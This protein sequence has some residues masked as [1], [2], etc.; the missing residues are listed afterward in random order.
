[1]ADGRSIW[2]SDD[3][4][5]LISKSESWSLNLEVYE[6]N[7]LRVNGDKLVWTND[8]E[9]LKN[10]LENVLKQ[11]GRW[12]TLVFCGISI[13]QHHPS[14]TVAQK[15]LEVR[16]LIGTLPTLPRKFFTLIHFGRLT[17]CTNICRQDELF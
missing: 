15:L 2:G 13:Y 9:S 3:N 14:C 4:H 6:L 12:L 17:E 8:L 7:Y 10:F 5:V 16:K 11:Q 1:M